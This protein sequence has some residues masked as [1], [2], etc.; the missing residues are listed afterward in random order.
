MAPDIATW[1]PTLPNVDIADIADIANG[2]SREA[3]GLTTPQPP[4]KALN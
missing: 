2:H 4:I 1:H 3:E